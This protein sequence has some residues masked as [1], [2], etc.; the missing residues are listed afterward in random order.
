M[1]FP[2]DTAEPGL[3]ADQ[4]LLDRAW[5]RIGAGLLVAGQA[6]AFSFAV[7]LTPPEGAVYWVLH[8][9]LML[10]AAGGAILG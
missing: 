7:N 6:M 5:L 4:R 3:Q 1:S 8:G 10:S 2:S 9:G